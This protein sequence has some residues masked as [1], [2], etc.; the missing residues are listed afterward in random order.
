[1]GIEKL[2]QFY[3]VHSSALRGSIDPDP[4]STARVLPDID[5]GHW[6]WDLGLED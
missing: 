6:K 1:M 4:F 2:C 5:F 3:N